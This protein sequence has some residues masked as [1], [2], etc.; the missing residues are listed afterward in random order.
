M[1]TFKDIANCI[2]SLPE[3]VQN[4]EASF[5]CLGEEVDEA[6]II[7]IPYDN[8]KMVKI[9]EKDFAPAIFGAPCAFYS[10]ACSNEEIA[11]EYDYNSYSF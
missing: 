2:L 1:A 8:I 7:S 10:I 5:C 6:A 9:V 4:C 11:D 3:D